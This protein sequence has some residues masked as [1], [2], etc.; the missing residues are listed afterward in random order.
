MIGKQ[1]HF[2]SKL[3]PYFELIAAA[4]RERSTWAQIAK[5]LK[6]RGTDCT[7]QGLASFFKSR[8]IRRGTAAESS[9][10]ELTSRRALLAKPVPQTHAKPYQ[11]PLWNHLET[12]RNLRK[13]HETWEGIASHLKD[14][15]GLEMSASTVLK[16]FKRAADGRVPIG[17]LGLRASSIGPARINAASA[18]PRATLSSQLGELKQI[19]EASDDPLLVEISNNDPFANLKRKYEQTRRA[20]G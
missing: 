19:P 10:V 12:I 14:D 15:H 13:Q 16:F 8:K 7:P 20:S 6:E 3:D 4:R 18:C 5:L 17:F 1:K 9:K 11:S 2:R